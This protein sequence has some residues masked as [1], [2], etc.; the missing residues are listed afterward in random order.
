[1]I[2]VDLSTVRWLL[3]VVAL[4]VVALIGCGADPEPPA[5]TDT[6]E[7]EPMYEAADM[8]GEQPEATD[9]S[10]EEAASTVDT[11]NTADGAYMQVSS[12][13]WSGPLLW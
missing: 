1:M 12:R 3:P 4:A 11:P 10:E 5:A 7:Q 9:T 6:A 8:P 2:S 13:L